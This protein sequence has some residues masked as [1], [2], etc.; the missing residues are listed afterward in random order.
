M[1]GERTPLGEAKRELRLRIRAARAGVTPAERESASEAVAVAAADLPE[2]A[3]ARVVLGYHA[4]PEEIDPAPLLATLRDRGAR[5]ALPR[6][7]E[8]GQLTWHWVNDPELELAPGPLGILEP[9]PG[10][11]GPSLHEVDLVVVPGVAFDERCS[12]LG[13][14][15][16]YYDRLLGRL[17]EGASAVALAYDVQV[18][19]EIPR[20]E[21]DRPVHVVVTPSGTVRA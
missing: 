5:V 19:P 12:R 21:T 13:F 15:G 16:G 20:C 6:V 4:L 10:T 14:G 3:G 8:G 7:A 18:L 9:A 17:H 1:P 2:V 11:G